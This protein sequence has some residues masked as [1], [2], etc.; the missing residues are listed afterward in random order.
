MSVLAVGGV[1]IWLGFNKNSNV[2]GPT[3]TSEVSISP[4]TSLEPS[5]TSSPTVSKSPLPTVSSQVGAKV[6]WEL[7]PKEASCELK[8][9]IKFLD[10]KTYD[11]Q[12]A[13]FTYSGIDH[14]ARNIHWAVVPEDALN[15]GPNIFARIPIPNGQSLLSVVLPEN[16]KYKK[17]ELY[18][19]V[20]YGRLVDAKGNIVTVGGNVKVFQ[21]QCS[22]KTTVVLP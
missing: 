19:I 16:P 3:P 9:E 6:P 22:G 15:V 8:G 18:A 5:F 17:Y 20:D 11:N 7:L 21:K 13:L 4:S 12:D 10:S 2:L 1:L 14:P